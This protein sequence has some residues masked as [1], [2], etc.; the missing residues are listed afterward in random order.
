[1]TRVIRTALATCALFVALAGTARADSA[2]EVTGTTGPS[3]PPAPDTAISLHLL[4]LA[5]RSL[6]AGVER[7]V[8]PG[9]RLSAVVTV[10]GRRSD[11][12]DYD[13]RAIGA[14]V[15]LRWWWRGRSLGTDF[16]SPAMVGWFLEARFDVTRTTLRAVEDDR[17]IG[18][19]TTLAESAGVGYRAALW[20]RLELT[21]SVDL[22][23]RTEIPSG[24]LPAWT[25]GGLS[26]GMTAGYLF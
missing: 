11:R 3:A 24:G 2:G 8:L 5:Q 9:P 18:H 14:G 12:G 20:R 23:V 17:A 6:A 10:A 19:T 4:G 25:R 15:G 16:A 26:F 7:F 1:M 22:S 13:A 21:G